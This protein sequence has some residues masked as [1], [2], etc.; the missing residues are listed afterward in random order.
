MFGASL[1][2]AAGPAR[3]G[4]PDRAAE[5][6]SGHVAAAKKAEAAGDT[7]TA[8]LEYQTAYAAAPTVYVLLL[9]IGLLFEK[10][11]EFADAYRAYDDGYRSSYRNRAYAYGE[12]C[13]VRVERHFNRYRGVWVVR[14][15]RTCD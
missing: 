15:I 8:L 1:L 4:A 10:R 13:R 9:H 3:A 7:A 6:T 5:A 14:R 12:G 11:N 2:L